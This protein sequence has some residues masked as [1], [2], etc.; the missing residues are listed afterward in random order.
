MMIVCLTRDKVC[1]GIGFMSKNYINL[2]AD[3][4]HAHMHNYAF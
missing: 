3:A 1:I 4:R 2:I